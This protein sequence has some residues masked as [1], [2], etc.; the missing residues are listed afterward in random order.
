MSRREPG[1]ADGFGHPQPQKARAAQRMGS[2][3]VAGSAASGGVSRKTILVKGC[4]LRAGEVGYQRNPVPQVL[5]IV[6]YFKDR[7]LRF[8]KRIEPP[9]R[10]IKSQ[11][12]FAASQRPHDTCHPTT[13]HQGR[14]WAFRA[15]PLHARFPAVTQ[16]QVLWNRCPSNPSGRNAN[17]Q[18]AI[19]QGQL[20]DEPACRLARR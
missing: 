6:S 12:N 4:A 3:F 5:R 14:S 15:N 9:P 8:L 17:L 18:Q 10:S 7:V 1:P 16:I 13:C 11:E 19:L 2:L 20:L